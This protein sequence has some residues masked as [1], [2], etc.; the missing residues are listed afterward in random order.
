MKGVLGWFTLK[1]K[2]LNSLAYSFHRLT[3]IVLLLYLIAHLSF[4]TSLRIGEETYTAFI[5]TTVKLETLPLDSLLFLATFYHAFNG[6][7]VV[8]NE[9]GL[10]YEARRALVYL[11]TLLA[12]VFWLYSTYVMYLFL[13]GW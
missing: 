2:S 13:T 3:G 6:L 4:L 11:M 12:L 8:L 7:R 1:G 5:S 10:L 9:F